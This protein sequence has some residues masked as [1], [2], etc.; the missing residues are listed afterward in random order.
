MSKPPDDQLGLFDRPAPYAKNSDTSRAA[1][2]SVEPDARTLRGIILAFIR[3]RGDFGATC[4]EIEVEL[5]LRHQTAS[6]RVFELREAKYIGDFA[7]RRKTRSG[8]AA[9]AWK[10]VRGK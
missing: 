7:S 9:V 5:G 6:A 10:A 4:D 2:A 8:R 3:G 1:A